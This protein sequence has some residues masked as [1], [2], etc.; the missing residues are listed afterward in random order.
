MHE[1]QEM[2]YLPTWPFGFPGQEKI[3]PG[4]EDQH[5]DSDGPHSKTLTTTEMPVARTFGLFPPV[6]DEWIRP[7]PKCIRR[8]APYGF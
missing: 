8:V 5:T 4:K 2:C 6:T 1:G 3:L 7:Q